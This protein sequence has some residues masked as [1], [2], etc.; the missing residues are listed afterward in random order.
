[1]SKDKVPFV[2]ALLRASRSQDDEDTLRRLLEN[3]SKN[4]ISDIELN[5]QDCSGRVSD[6]LPSYDCFQLFSELVIFMLNVQCV[7][8][9][10]Y[11]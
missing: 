3:I 5:A 9:A 2:T 7:I 4:G 6:P 1:M 11:T 10:N 8:G